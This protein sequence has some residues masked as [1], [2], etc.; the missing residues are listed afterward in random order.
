MP[1]PRLSKVAM[2]SYNTFLSGHHPNGWIEDKLFVVQNDNGA[3]WGSLQVSPTRAEI[4]SLK[5]K[6]I[7]EVQGFV[8][9]HWQ[10]LS[11]I[12]PELD[13]VIIYVGDRGSEHT[14]EYAAKFG[15]KPDK[16]VFVLCDCNLG[17]KEE[18]INQHGF[19]TSKRIR[20]ECGGHGI[21]NAI[22]KKFLAT[23]ELGI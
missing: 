22:A 4:P 6:G 1:Q 8:A 18:K 16:A 23:G 7:E 11:G 3:K 2:L 20:C 13:K 10:Q 5:A 9:N 14:I 12:I 21:M 15:L 17:E 19:S